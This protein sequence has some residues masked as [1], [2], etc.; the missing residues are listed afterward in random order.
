MQTEI[1]TTIIASA[2]T[3]I[4]AFVPFVAKYKRVKKKADSYVS[5]GLAVGYYYN[6]VKPVFEILEVTEM[7]VDINRKGS[8]DVESTRRFE[9]EHVDIEIIIPRELSKP[10]IRQAQDAAYTYRKGTILRKKDKRNFTIN[11]F[12]DEDNDRLTIVDVANPLNGVLEYLENLNEFKYIFTDSGERVNNSSSD[13]FRER[14]A[15]E[16]RNFQEAILD[17][18]KNEGYAAN[19][20]KFRPLQ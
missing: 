10:A 9:S 16:I 5:T 2:T 3:V 18:T 1:I 11:F 17:F 4:V 15:K 20:I 7:T 13:K 6:F 19:K 14:Q 8:N 12:I